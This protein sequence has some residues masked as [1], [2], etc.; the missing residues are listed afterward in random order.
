MLHK[1]DIFPALLPRYCLL[2]FRGNYFFKELDKT[3]SKSLYFKDLFFMYASFLKKFVISLKVSCEAG[4]SPPFPW[5]AKHLA[6]MKVN[7]ILI[8][9][10]SLDYV[11]GINEAMLTYWD[12]FS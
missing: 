1:N 4:L 10:C 11:L 12:I 8:I 9:K 7:D 6:L 2:K 5:R 3:S